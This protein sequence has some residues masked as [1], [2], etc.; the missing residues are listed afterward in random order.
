MRRFAA[1]VL[2]ALIL[3][4]SATPAG[5][6]TVPDGTVSWLSTGDSF[7]S[8]HGI[9]GNA[10]DCA[11]SAGAW[12]L[13]A[14]NELLASHRWKIGK[15]VFSACTGRV[16]SDFYNR[17]ADS[18][19]KGSLWEW[20][21]EQAGQPDPKFDVITLSFGGNDLDF[22]GVAKQCIL[23]GVCQTSEA[24]LIDRVAQL[25][26]P[27]RF[28]IDDGGPGGTGEAKKGSMADLY[29][30]IASRHLTPRGRL[31]I[32]GYPRL[33]A[34]AGEWPG[35]SWAMCNNVTR[36]SADMLGRVSEA[37]DTTLASAVTKANRSVGGRIE[38]VSAVDLW[39]GKNASRSGQG[40]EQ[41]GAG[42]DWLNGPNTITGTLTDTKA[43]LQ[44]GSLH[45]NLIGHAA[46]GKAVADL[47]AARGLAAKPTFP[48]WKNYSY[49][50]GLC[51]SDSGPMPMTAGKTTKATYDNP[52]VERPVGNLESVVEGDL[53][54]DGVPE[55][56]V[57]IS[58]NRSGVSGGGARTATIWTATGPAA[59][60]LVVPDVSAAVGAGGG[61]DSGFIFDAKVTA[62]I[63]MVVAGA[64]GPGDPAG[65]PQS[66][67][68]ARFRLEG[69][70]LTRQ[71][72]IKVAAGPDRDAV[73]PFMV[74]L[75]YGL[76]VSD[77][78]T[79][80]AAKAGK[81][82]NLKGAILFQKSCRLDGDVTSLC[83]IE[84]SRN[85][86]TTTVTVV[87]QPDV[88]SDAEYRDGEY[89]RNGKPYEPTK[90][91]VLDIKG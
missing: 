12:G 17:R 2:C 18:G 6:E 84:V 71:G 47:L 58:C 56:V 5:A 63:L 54:G 87:H 43:G 9:P 52:T 14:V 69:N 23:D 89:I 4:A 30:T 85:S 27:T 83:E 74:G 3:A 24:D 41:C 1:L 37:L 67:Q 40:H 31:V 76:D 13:T 28:V 57:S 34:P 60:T 70:R 81:A 38:Y 73:G 64:N 44:L 33:Y 80:E 29:G 62:G 8:G 59:A 26:S 25:N 75:A 79:P 86:A 90:F 88:P 72:T 61:E 53:T 16:V 50:K 49:P 66:R 51:G 48:D 42:E 36:S 55:A 46:A 21:K 22:S 91:I 39:G 20:T 11:Q 45:P 32:M 7:S 68:V 82:L 78:A 15:P 65:Q 35:W 77:V 10:G 19:G